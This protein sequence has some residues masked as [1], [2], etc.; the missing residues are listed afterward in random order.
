MYRPVS[1]ASIAPVQGERSRRIVSGM[2][3]RHRI[4]ADVPGLR[5]EDGT[6]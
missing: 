5:T 4:V 6:P 3:D 2:I 1:A